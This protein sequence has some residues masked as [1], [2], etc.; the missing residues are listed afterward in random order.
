MELARRGWSA[1]DLAREAGISPPTVSAALAGK[2]IAARSVGLVAAC[3]ARFPAMEI[4][5]GLIMG[6][7]D[8]VA[9]DEEPGRPT[10]GE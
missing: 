3:L 4:L 7:R 8:G 6:D 5:E 2:P 10:M 9:R 1:A